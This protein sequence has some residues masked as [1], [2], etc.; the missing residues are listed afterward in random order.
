ME[1]V[2]LHSWTFVAQVM[3]ANDQYLRATPS[4]AVEVWSLSGFFSLSVGHQRGSFPYFR[5]SVAAAKSNFTVK[6]FILEC[7]FLTELSCS[8]VLKIQNAH[9][10]ALTLTNYFLRHFTG[11]NIAVIEQRKA[12]W[13]L[14]LNIRLIS[15][16]DVTKFRVANFCSK[17]NFPGT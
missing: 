2:S 1:F 7:P 16:R 9:V 13:E 4:N 6:Q 10:S 15:Q 11:K 14:C 8:V 17:Y 12:F 5:V 3:A